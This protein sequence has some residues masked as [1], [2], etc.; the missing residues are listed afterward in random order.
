MDGRRNSSQKGFTKTLVS[1]IISLATH[2]NPTLFVLRHGPH[3]DD[4][5]DDDSDQAGTAAAAAAHQQQR[6]DAT[7]SVLAAAREQN[8]TGQTTS[9]DEFALKLYQGLKPKKKKKNVHGETA[10]DAAAR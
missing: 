5:D 3:G 2:N 6:V 8:A 1:I 10:V 4:D 9:R 7:A